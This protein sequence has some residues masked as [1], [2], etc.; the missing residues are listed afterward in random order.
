VTEHASS[1]VPVR[2]ELLEVSLLLPEGWTVQVEPDA[3]TLTSVATDDLDR[4]GLRPSITV[5]RHPPVG[6]DDLQALAGGTLDDMRRTYERFDLRWNREEAQTHRVV[7][8]YEFVL[9]GLARAVRQVQGL[10]TGEHLFV[11]NCTQPAEGP[12]LEAA[13]VAVV[14]SLEPR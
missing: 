5:E 13:F 9:P 2:D 6:W 7:R 1:L 12:P 4:D 3:P 8:A 14:E 10:I 11:V